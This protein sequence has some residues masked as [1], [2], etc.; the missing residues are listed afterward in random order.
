MVYMIVKNWKSICCIWKK[1]G[2]QT[3]LTYYAR[4]NIGMYNGKIFDFFL[5][6]LHD[7]NIEL[8]VHSMDLIYIKN[9]NFLSYF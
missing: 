3:N 5:L 2:F 1:T 8:K 4:I 9:M 6:F 7:N